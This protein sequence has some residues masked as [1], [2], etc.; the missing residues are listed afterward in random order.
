MIQLKK[1]PIPTISVYGFNMETGKVEHL[2]E[3]NEL[4]FNDLR[5]QIKEFYKNNNVAE[6]LFLGEHSKEI[7]FFSYGKEEFEKTGYGFPIYTD[8]KLYNAPVEFSLINE[9][10]DKLINLDEIF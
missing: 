1:I 6:S 2:A 10:L 5:V 4:E 7:S 3:A 8:G 9:Q